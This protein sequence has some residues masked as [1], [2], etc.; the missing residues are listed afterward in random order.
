MLVRQ[1]E[2]DALHQAA[3]KRVADAGRIDD[4]MRARPPATSTRPPA[5]MTDD[6]CSPRVTISAFAAPRMLGFAE[7]GLLPQQLELVVVADD[8][9]GADDA[10]AQLVAR[11]ARAL[12]A[13]VEDERD[14]ERAALLG[15]LHHR[16]RIVRRDDRQP[17]VAD[18]P[19]RQLP[20][21]GHRAGVERRD[22]IVVDVGAAEERRGE[23]ARRSASRATC[24]RRPPRATRGTRRSPRPPSPSAAAARRAAPACR[25]CSA[26]SRRAACPSCRRES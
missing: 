26:R 14:A 3:A 18:R 7:A 23:L 16:A 20:G 9:G 2:R 25:R 22:L 15:V 8:D 4:A 11:H 24:R 19:E 17:A 21:V 12:L 10:V 13:R 1:P 5:V 6:P